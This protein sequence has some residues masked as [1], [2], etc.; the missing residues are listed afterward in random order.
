MT[1]VNSKKYEE[2]QNLIQQILAKNFKCSVCDFQYTEDILK[3]YS[4][5][6]LNSILN[7]G[8]YRIHEHNLYCL[9]QYKHN[10]IYKKCERCGKDIR[11][12]NIN[13]L[14]KECLMQVKHTHT[15]LICGN[16]FTVKSNKQNTVYCDSC[17]A[18]DKVFEKYNNE[19]LNKEF[20]VR[21]IILRNSKYLY[22]LFFNKFFNKDG[23]DKT[24]SEYAKAKLKL[25]N[26][27]ALLLQNFIIHITNAAVKFKWNNDTISNLLICLIN[28]EK[29][30]EHFCINKTV[31][32]FNYKAELTGWSYVLNNIEFH[33]IIETLNNFSISSKDGKGEFFWS[34]IN[35]QI[36]C[37]NKKHAD[38]LYSNN[39]LGEVKSALTSS[40]A[41]RLLFKRDNWFG[42]NDAATYHRKIIEELQM[43][44]YLNKL[45]F[46]VTKFLPD[47]HACSYYTGYKELINYISELKIKSKTKTVNKI[48]NDLII[49]I[50]KL[51]INFNKQFQLRF[52]ELDLTDKNNFKL[53]HFVNYCLYYILEDAKSESLDKLIFVSNKEN[54]IL[55][56]NDLLN[57]SK[58]ELSIKIKNWEVSYPTPGFTK[59]DN[60]SHDRNKDRAPGIYTLIN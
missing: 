20:E 48:I 26:D 57:L 58:E 49:Y 28:C 13:T 1:K 25:F 38:I 11:R 24:S 50:F 16:T 6:S 33:Q 53:F 4:I 44:L 5:K 60:T 35:K 12:S 55:S 32:N 17:F 54:L 41:G 39:S 31:T 59:K 27:L 52:S 36:I 18:S 47:V 30:V 37:N 22:N 8:E 45:K 7:K 10:L 9:S 21:N 46:D 34:I 2:K 42:F 43:F 14:C 15:C 56:K 40:T 29:E 23:F 51:T 19:Y 3:Y